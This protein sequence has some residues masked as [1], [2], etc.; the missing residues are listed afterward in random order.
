MSDGD[1][2]SGRSQIGAF[3]NGQAITGTDRQGQVVVDDSFLLLFNGHHE[4]VDWTLPKHWGGAWT[5]LLDTAGPD[6]EGQDAE[7]G[8]RLPVAARSVTALLHRCGAQ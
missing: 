1:W 4:A 3:L 8:Q 6:R 2:E 5:V 7:A